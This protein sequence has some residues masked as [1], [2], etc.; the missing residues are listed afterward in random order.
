MYL[1]NIKLGTKY[2]FKDVA[3]RSYLILFL[4]VKVKW[5]SL[6]LHELICAERNMLVLEKA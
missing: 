3:N 2:N 5:H 6:F 1:G 4:R